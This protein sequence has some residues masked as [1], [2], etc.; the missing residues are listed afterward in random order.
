MARADTG[1]SVTEWLALP[2]ADLPEWC[3][4]VADEQMLVERE[5]EKHR[6]K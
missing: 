6:K 4:I 2:V 3:A 1:T 5:F